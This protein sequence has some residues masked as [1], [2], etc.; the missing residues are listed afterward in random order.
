[1]SFAGARSSLVYGTRKGTSGSASGSDAR[2]KPAF[3]A[4]NSRAV[5]HYGKSEVGESQR[6][7]SNSQVRG[8]FPP[9]YRCKSEAHANFSASGRSL[10]AY[11]DRPGEVRPIAHVENGPLLPFPAPAVLG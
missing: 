2:T 7:V 9:K 8:E 4:A 10:Q 3:S 11:P 6:G 1:M 5:A